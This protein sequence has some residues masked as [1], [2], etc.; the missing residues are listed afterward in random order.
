M[1]QLTSERENHERIQA[2]ESSFG[3]SGRPLSKPG[4]FLMGE[5]QLLKQGRRKT[6]SKVFFLFNDVLVYGSIILNG[7]WHK[8]QNIIP[9]GEQ[10]VFLSCGCMY[11]CV[12]TVVSRLLFLGKAR[13][14]FVLWFNPNPGSSTEGCCGWQQVFFATKQQ[15]T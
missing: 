4:R 6:V 10:L 3:P 8:N 1:D 13:A 15:H 7:R 2:V 11:C 5:G 12:V 14:A 9:L